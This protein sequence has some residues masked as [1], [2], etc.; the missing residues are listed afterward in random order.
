MTSGTLYDSASLS[1]TYAGKDA[2]TGLTLTPAATIADAGNYAVTLVST[3][4]GEIDPK[5]LTVT[6]TGLV[7]KTY[8]ATADATVGADNIQLSGIVAGDAVTASATSAAYASANAGTG[9][10]MTASGVG[11]GGAQARD[12]TLVSTTYSA[13]IGQIDPRSITITANDEDKFVGQADPALTYQ[14]TSGSFV[15]ADAAS[16][17]LSRAAG[18]TPGDY[19]IQ[20]GS[21]AV[22]GNYALT[23][24]AGQFVINPSGGVG[25]LAGE[26]ADQSGFSSSSASFTLASG[27]RYTPSINPQAIG[28][29]D[30]QCH[31]DRN[32]INVPYPANLDVGPDIR[33]VPG[34]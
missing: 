8:D 2:G 33:F 20:Q 10:A 15:G 12:Y 25:S 32:C 6:L 17:A 13:N 26:T 34:L 31:I 18:Q 21:L 1:E 11:L 7:D 23:F 30:A 16:G 28:S 29:S 5:A 4:N 27:P 24:V 19:A 22:S 9:I 14:V 3:A